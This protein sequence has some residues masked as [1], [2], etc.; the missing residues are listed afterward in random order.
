MVKL[1]K[2]IRLIPKNLDKIWEVF[3][4]PVR[5]ADNYPIKVFPFADNNYYPMIVFLP[6]KNYL[7]DVVL[8][9][10]LGGAHGVRVFCHGHASFS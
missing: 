9:F 10:V 5:F 1:I 8:E 2:L 6:D 3:Y 4:G 7:V